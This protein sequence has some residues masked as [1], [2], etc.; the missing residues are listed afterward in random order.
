MPAEQSCDVVLGLQPATIIL[1]F[2]YFNVKIYVKI[3]NF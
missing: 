2:T 1:D 3:R